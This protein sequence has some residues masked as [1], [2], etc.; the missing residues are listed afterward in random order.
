MLLLLLLLLQ[1]IP[2][3]INYTPYSASSLNLKIIW[4]SLVL[5]IFTTKSW[6]EVVRY[7][8]KWCNLLL[9]KWVN[10]NW[11]LF[12]Y[13][14]HYKKPCIVSFWQLPDDCFSWSMKLWV[15]SKCFWPSS[16]LH[17]YI[18]IYTNWQSIFARVL[19]SCISEILCIFRDLIFVIGP[20]CFSYWELRESCC[21]YLRV[22]FHHHVIIPCKR[23]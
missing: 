16:S 12:S 2:L 9:L 8:E 17:T 21:V 1:V 3:K 20:I 11:S 19:M 22:D 13:I 5:Q 15:A 7:S 6:F 23:T 10:E 18:Y 4:F 14:S